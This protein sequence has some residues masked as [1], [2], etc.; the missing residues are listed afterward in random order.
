MMS[1]DCNNPKTYSPD[2]AMLPGECITPLTA[3][4]ETTIALV[5]VLISCFIN[6]RCKDSVEYR[7][8]YS[9]ARIIAFIALLEIP[10]YFL[11]GQLASY[12]RFRHIMV[13]MGKGNVTCG[14]Y[15]VLCSF[16]LAFLAST[17]R[18]VVRLND[19][20]L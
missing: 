5:F 16:S 13:I 14:G 9:P 4:P 8:G 2:V 6:S 1:T 18:R 10:E 19:I 12:Y 7:P 17:S 3:L 15:L 20:V 11:S